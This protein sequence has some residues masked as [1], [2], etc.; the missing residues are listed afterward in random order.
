M[1]LPFFVAG[2]LSVTVV[3]PSRAQ[4]VNA[5]ARLVDE[6]ENRIKGYVKLRKQLEGH[7]L[8]LKP[9]VSPEKI[10]RHERELAERIRQ[11]RR[12]AA[13]GSIFTPEI[14]AEFR[15]LIGIA[16]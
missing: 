15:R 7:L 12:D 16:M 9:T 11:A 3:T 5:D 10:A 8:A 2:I 4:K 13:Q 1:K 14:A 6:F